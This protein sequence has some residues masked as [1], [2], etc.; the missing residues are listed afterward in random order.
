M[1]RRRIVAAVGAVAMTLSVV[2]LIAAPAG[3]ISAPVPVAMGLD[4]PYK[5][6]FGPDGALY[7]AEAGTAG[8]EECIERE[9][10][11]SGEIVEACY[12]ATGG[13]TR[14]DLE[15]GEQEQVV[16]GLPS[17]GGDGEA[18]GPSDVA[19]SPEGVLHVIIGLGGD[20]EF[21]DHFSDPRIGTIVKVDDEVG[22]EIVS[23]LAQFEAD[24]D[25]DQVYNQD[26]PEGMPPLSE[27]DSNPFGLTF[28]GDDILA[29]DAGGNTVLRI[30]P[31]GTTTVEQLLPL[32]QAEAPPFLGLPP[33]TMIPHQPVPTA[34][35]V[36]A[37]GTPLVGQLTGFPFPVGGASVF[38][39]SGELDVVADGFTNILD[40][41]VDVETGNVYVLEFTD[42]GLLSEDFAPSLIQL[43]PDGTRKYLMHGDLPPL[44]GVEV[45]PDGM[46]YVTACT[47]CG[48]GAG[49]V[50]QLD[51]SVPSDPATADACSPDDVPGTGFPDIKA[52]THREAIECMAFWGAVEGFLDGTY[53]PQTPIRRDQV[54]S[55]LA[56]ALSAAGVELPND[57][58]D[59]FGDDD[60]THEDNINALAALGVVG[61]YPDG[62]Y[63]GSQLVT[64]AQIASMFARAWE[65]VTGEPLAQGT[66][67]FSDDAGSVH[68]DNIDAVAAMG[69][70]NGV[71]EGAFAPQAPTVRGQFASILARMLSSLVETGVAT[72]PT[73]PA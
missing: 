50:W 48:P 2:P 16:T 45:G 14:I 72:V 60:G 41:D 44:G 70:V 42:N 18:G 26:L 61:G 66:D 37:E 36:D 13:V 19:F 68:E 58:P 39:A 47:L 8:D 11:E 5:L 9:D 43:R 1:N 30:T 55:M 23:D 46:V 22:T 40:I 73:P 54:A 33:G 4:T 51:P 64:R 17:I 29:V 59:A 12:G 3:A 35:D 21:R 20:L 65:A 56:R 27:V 32:G 52:N 6:T 38:D 28:D 34:I 63:R 69:W 24:N 53:G 15:S 71:G 31:D 25:P 10:P 67:A 57:P 49:M 7:V 62:T